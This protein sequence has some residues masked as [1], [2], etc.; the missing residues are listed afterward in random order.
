MMETAMDLKLGGRRA[1]VTGSTA[2]IGFAIAKELA[3]EQAA[4]IVN[5]RT[6]SSVKDAISRIQK[7]VP[8]AK[9][10]G[11]A[12]DAASAE[13]AEAILA[14]WPH[15]DIL[16]NSLGIFEPKNFFEITDD[17]WRRF[18]DVNVLGGV[19]LARR[20]GQ[21]MA[22]RK[23][24]RIL[25][26]SSESAINIPREMIHYGMT[27]TAQI[28]ISRGL[29]IELAATGVTVNSLLPGPTRTEG[30]V[31][32]IARLAKENDKTVPA[33][34]EDFFKTARPSSLIRRFADPSEVASMAVYLCSDRAS[35]TTGAAVRVDGGL[36]SSIVP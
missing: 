12:T 1:L 13:G 9:V 3:A 17:E 35:A 2:G 24:G 8:A 32:F 22:A 36:I 21:A 31:D 33:M 14:R 30:V 6:E 5:G 27:K 34:E 26:I 10:E 15:V 29:A 20:Y 19:R 4:V 18:F 23:W 25:F 11:I 16:V 7:A 28:A